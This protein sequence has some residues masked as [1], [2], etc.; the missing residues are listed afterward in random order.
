MC[1]FRQVSDIYHSLPEGEKLVYDKK[2]RELVRAKLEASRQARTLYEIPSLTVSKSH[3]LYL[4]DVKKKHIT[5]EML[6]E[7]KQQP[8]E[9]QLSYKNKFKRLKEEKEAELL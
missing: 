4:H 1:N 9:V 8:K 3:I 6:G 7:F 5:K 2:M